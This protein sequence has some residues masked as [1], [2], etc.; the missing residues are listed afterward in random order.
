MASKKKASSKGSKRGARKR[1]GKGENF[2]EAKASA[3]EVRTAVDTMELALPAPNDYQHH[4]KALLGALDKQRTANSLVRTARKNAIAA[5][6]DPD[7][8]LEA[9][10]IVRANDPKG[11]AQ[12]M[13][14]LA[15]A[16]EQEGFP[17]QFIIH[18]S[19]AGDQEELVA[20]RGYEDGKAARPANNKYPAASDLALVYDTHWKRGQAENMAG[21]TQA[22]ANGQ[23][24]QETAH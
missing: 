11:T 3:V 19:L 10:R 7:S 16:L 21:I 13:A 9:N 6:V 15:F 2:T 5:G 8:V 24:I 22:P 12:K 1:R 4:K 23:D 18:D 14:Q 20:K 17:I